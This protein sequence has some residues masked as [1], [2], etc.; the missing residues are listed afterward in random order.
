MRPVQNGVICNGDFSAFTDHRYFK[1]IDSDPYEIPRKR[2]RKDAILDKLPGLKTLKYYDLLLIDRVKHV[3][4]V[5]TKQAKN[6]PKVGSKLVERSTNCRDDKSQNSRK[7]TRKPLDEEDSVLRE[8]KTKSH[9]K[10]RLRDVDMNES[11]PLAIY[12]V[13]SHGSGLKLRMRRKR[14]SSDGSSV[15]SE[16]FDESWDSDAPSTESSDNSSCRESSTA[17]TEKNSY[18]S[19]TRRIS[20]KRCPCCR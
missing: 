18:S 16:Q 12:K 19:R 5:L 13:T 2:R 6:K 7:E 11:I 3:K 1:E 14:T 10:I 8:D 9:D 17:S 4:P 20:Q 15:N